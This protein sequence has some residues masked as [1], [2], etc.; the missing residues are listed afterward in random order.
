MVVL[1]FI[2]NR[3]V[4]CFT[5][6]AFYYIKMISFSPNACTVCPNRSQTWLEV[7]FWVYDCHL[8]LGCEFVIET[9][10]L[11][12]YLMVCYVGF[13]SSWDVRVSS[14]GFSL[15]FIWFS[16]LLISKIFLPIWKMLC[17]C[18]SKLCWRNRCS[19]YWSIHCT[20]PERKCWANYECSSS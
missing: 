16:F 7:F 10:I 17:L 11:L 19:Y 20:V 8:F 13:P 1:L 5:Q 3:R 15:S 2:R 4:P 6:F 18:S 12:R 9:L 14:T